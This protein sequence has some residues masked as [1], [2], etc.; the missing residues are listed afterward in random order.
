M[1]GPAILVPKG[2]HFICHGVPP[3]QSYSMGYLCVPP[4]HNVAMQATTSWYTFES[5]DAGQVGPEVGSKW[6]VKRLEQEA[7]EAQSGEARIQLELGS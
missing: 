2:W 6:S 5:G 3:R 1:G 4:C 7:S